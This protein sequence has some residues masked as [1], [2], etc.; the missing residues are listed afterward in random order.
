[1]IPFLVALVLA[2]VGGL[3]LRFSGDNSAKETPFFI[4]FLVGIILL[5]VF[6]AGVFFTRD[7]YIGQIIHGRTLANQ[8]ASIKKNEPMDE[9]TRATVVIGVRQWNNWMI[10]V[11]YSNNSIW[12]WWHPDEVMTLKEI[13]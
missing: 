7:Y 8:Y 11:K 2:L 12:D 4:S 3:Y 6:S 13:E 9:H 5:V 1:M 10:L